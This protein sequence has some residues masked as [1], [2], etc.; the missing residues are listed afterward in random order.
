MSIISVDDLFGKPKGLLCLTTPAVP[1]IIYCRVSN[2]YQERDGNLDHQVRKLFLYLACRNVD[3]VQVYREQHKGWT[4]DRPEFIRAIRHAK[5]DDIP[6]VAMNI[7]RLIRPPKGWALDVSKILPEHRKWFRE[8]SVVFALV[9]PFDAS[10]GEKR[11]EE[12]KRGMAHKGKMGGRPK[13]SSAARDKMILKRHEIGYS[14]R[15]IADYVKTSKSTVHRV[16]RK[17]CPIKG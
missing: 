1:A 16:V 7:D 13:I 6:I 14:L 15:E 17:H 3:V 11:S 9:K 8:H 10:L 2:P 12:T 4:L 5:R